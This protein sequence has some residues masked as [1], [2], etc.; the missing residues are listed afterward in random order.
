LS[1]SD[2]YLPDWM[3]RAL[4]DFEMRREQVEVGWDDWVFSY[5][6]DTQTRLAQA[7]GFGQGALALV[8][9]GAIL[10]CFL[11]LRRLTRRRTVVPAFENL[12]ARFCRNMAQR[13]IPRAK[14]EGPLAYTDRVAEAFPEKK[15]AIQHF[16]AI[17]ARSR[18]GPS[19]VE[20]TTPKE[21]QALLT[22]IAASQAAASS[23]HE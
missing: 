1:F 7:L 17:V 4:V 21:L 2:A 15:E 10:L 5:N 3:N 19:P 22:Q 18:Y 9:A 11:I 6:P 14:W 8:S 12:Y 16:G 23:A 13:G 20:P